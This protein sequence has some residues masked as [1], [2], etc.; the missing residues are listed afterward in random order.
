MND[1]FDESPEGVFIES[2]LAAQSQ[3]EREQIGRQ[4]KQKMVA[5]MQQGFWVFKAPVGYKY[6]K[7]KGGG[8]VLVPDE[9]LAPVVIEALEGFAS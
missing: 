3:L 6:V 9:D 4:S 8:K 7:A 2:I 5:R 1:N